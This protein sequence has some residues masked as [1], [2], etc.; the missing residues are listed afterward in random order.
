MKKKSSSTIQT[1]TFYPENHHR[2]QRARRFWQCWRKYM[3]RWVLRFPSK[4]ISNRA[5]ELVQARQVRRAQSL[6]QIICLVTNSARKTW[7]GLPCSEKKW[8]PASSTRT[9]L[10]HVST[11]ALP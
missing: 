2:I 11:G 4:K 10:R 3:K 8:H 1:I 7:F 5:A 6:E 9:I